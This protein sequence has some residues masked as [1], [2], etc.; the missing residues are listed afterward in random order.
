MSIFLDSLNFGKT[1]KTPVWFMRQAGRHLPEYMKIRSSYRNLIEM[2]KDPSICS[3][4]TLQPIERYDLDAAIIFT[5]ILM[6]HM[7]KGADVSFD[8]PGGPIVEFKSKEKTNFNNINFLYEAIKIT[9]NKTNKPLI[10]F[11]GGPWTTLTYSMFSPTERK[12][13]QNHIKPREKEIEKK[14]KEVT[15]LTIEHSIKQIESGIDA[16]QLFESAAGILDDVQ[17]NRWCLEPCKLI[18]KEIKK[19]KN[20]PIIV[21]PRG[22]SLKN[23]ISYSN[24]ID[25]NCLSVDQFFDLKNINKL[26]INKTIQG[27]LD[28]KT[29]RLGGKKLESEIHKILLAFRETPHIFNLGHGVLKDTPIANVAK[30]INIIR[31]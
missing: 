21:F 15:E 8:K 10:G 29:L 3:K 23:Y 20:I 9:K 22:V 26:N 16:F 2:F 14:I 1:K 6:I 7:I 25:L 27:N 18:L 4:V 13:L 11:A 5:D 17:L 28:P 30:A 24:I 19:H 31:S 12:E